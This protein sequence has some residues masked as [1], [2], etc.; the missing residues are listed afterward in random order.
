MNILK[1]IIAKGIYYDN[2]GLKSYDVW[3]KKLINDFGMET[4]QYMRDIRKWSL[5]L[6]VPDNNFA[7]NKLNCWEFM[8]CNFQPT[9]LD[10]VEGQRICPVVTEAKFDGTNGGRN[11]GRSCWEVAHTMCFGT[12]QDTSQQKYETCSIC[13][14]YRF[15]VEDEGILSDIRTSKGMFY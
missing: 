11:A 7:E 9:I 5:L 13:D 14:F 6:P 4:I 8:G 15:V 2:I 1:D 12:A 3:A 10:E